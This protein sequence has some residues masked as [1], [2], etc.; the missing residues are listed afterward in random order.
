MEANSPMEVILGIIATVII[1]GI[2][3]LIHEFGHFIFA[4]RAGIL[5]HEF[6]LGMGPVVYKKKVGETVYCIRALPIGGFVSMAGEEVSDAYIKKGQ[7]IGLNLEDDIVKE[8]VMSKTKEKEI[9]GR[10]ISYDLYGKDN[11]ELYVT[12]DVNGEEKRFVVSRECEYIFDKGENIKLSV[13]ERSLES[14]SK[15]HRFMTIFMGAGM[16]FVLAFFLYMLVSLFVGSPNFKSAEIGSVSNMS[17]NETVLFEHDIIREIKVNNNWVVVADWLEFSDK[18]DNL[19]GNQKIE[20][21]VERNNKLE[22][23]SLNVTVFINS[24]GIGSSHNT[25]K[26]EINQV[27]GKGPEYGFKQGDI[28]KSIKYDDKVVEIESWLQLT[29][30]FKDFDIKTVDFYLENRTDVITVETYGN[31]VLNNQGVLKVDGKIGVS[32]TY[33]FNFADFIL[34]G[35]VGIKNVAI[36]VFGTIGLLFGNEQIGVGDLSGPVGIFSIISDLLGDGFWSLVSFTAFLSVNLGVMN[37][38][39]IPALDGGR[40]VF[41]GYEAVTKKPVNKKV[42]NT[43]NTIM[44]F[45]L[46]GLMLFVLYN[47]ALRLG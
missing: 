1:L 12:L 11:A 35:F 3:I 5:C 30:I 37:L 16:N 20:L 24:I 43:L 8:I 23:V 31:E 26:V 42:E 14:K 19:V 7:V 46:M 40:L 28:V 38:L 13:H 18:M 2:V 25:D 15:K 47:D 34:S 9:T 41:L 32:P 10:V 22:E 44:L 33:K 21:K 27:F 4:K 17:G 36:Q 39:P 45:L 29:N 6:S